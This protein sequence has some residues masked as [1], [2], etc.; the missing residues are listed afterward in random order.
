MPTTR[1]IAI[2]MGAESGRVILGTIEGGRIALEVIHRFPSVNALAEGH[3]RWDLQRIFGEICTGLELVGKR[4][5]AVASIGV[6][7]WGVDYGL[8]ADGSL[9]EGAICYRDGRTAD[10]VE[11]V[12]AKVGGAE[13]I[14]AR[15]GVAS[16]VFNT[17]FQL[18]AHQ[19]QRPESL[20]RAQGMLFIPDL[21]HHWLGGEAVN[22]W[23]IAG[24]AQLCRAGRPEWDAQLI[25]TLGLPPHLFGRI[26]KPGTRTG[27][28]KPELAA[29]F[30]FAV[31]PAIVVPASHDTAA[32]VG[33][34]PGDP[35]TTIYLSSGT[36]SLLGCVADL[37]LTSPEALKA[38][39]GNETSADGRTRINR[40]IMGL[41]LLQE[42]RRAF[43]AQGKN[44]SYQQM[45]DMAAAKPASAVALD[46]NDARF[47]AATG[48]GAAP[49][50][51]RVAAWCRERGHAAPAD[52]AAL[53]RFIVDGLAA[54]YGR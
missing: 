15:T 40:N 16:L 33:A 35:N 28:L 20:A 30:G 54:T 44:Y 14:F 17:S 48:G 27:Q 39:W 41:W 49:M 10:E 4:G 32:A 3:L 34:S 11:R 31:P 25:A 47:L 51:E 24:T 9:V 1:H 22:E 43:E 6:D 52:D 12:H 36:W 8:V 38:G 21:I 26:V 18:A 37:P 46:V 13:A 50:P 42:T 19:R 53:V 45:A 7:T 5:V 23:S 2:D 29:R